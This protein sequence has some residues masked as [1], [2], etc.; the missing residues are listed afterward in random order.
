MINCLCSRE[1]G[2][3]LFFRSANLS[4]SS[5]ESVDTDPEDRELREVEHEPEAWSITVEKTRLKTMSARDIK[6]QDHIWGEIF[7][8]RC[9]NTINIIIF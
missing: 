8:G 4:S 3:L 1:D 7:A 9:R 6:R 2:V 5:V